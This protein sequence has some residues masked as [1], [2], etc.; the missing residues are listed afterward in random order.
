MENRQARL[1]EHWQAMRAELQQ[2]ETAYTRALGKARLAKSLGNAALKATAAAEL[3]QAVTAVTQ[4]RSQ[5]SQARY[6][7]GG[8]MNYRPLEPAR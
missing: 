3:R 1:N 4:A 5:E 8:R 7:A 2:A 6:L